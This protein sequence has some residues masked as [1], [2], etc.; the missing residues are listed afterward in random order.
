MRP[1][2]SAER[3]PHAR[4]VTEA[5]GEAIVAADDEH[6]RRAAVVAPAAE[7]RRERGAI[8]ALAA[9]V[10]DEGDGLVGNNIGQRDRFF[11]HP[12]ANLLGT[13]FADFHNIHVTKAD[14]P[15][16]LLGALAIALGELALGAILE[17]ADGG[18]HQP[19]FI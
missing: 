4:L 3:E 16:G 19:H 5:G 10:E 13:A 18:N 1:G 15:A 9:R 14:V 12:L 2:G 17:P 11:D 8:Q 6:G 7:P